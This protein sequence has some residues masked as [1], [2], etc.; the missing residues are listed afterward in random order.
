MCEPYPMPL[1]ILRLE[2]TLGQVKSLIYNFILEDMHG[3][4]R[5]GTIFLD[6]MLFR[7]TLTSQTLTMISLHQVTHG[8]VFSVSG[9]WFKKTVRGNRAQF[10]G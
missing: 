8:E 2:A 4:W 3:D 6:T 7:S 9:V 1:H 5:L 10:S